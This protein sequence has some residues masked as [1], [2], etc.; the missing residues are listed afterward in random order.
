MATF[1]VISRF[2][3]TYV[4]SLYLCAPSV[5]TVTTTRTSY[6]EVRET[7]KQQIFY[8]LFLYIHYSYAVPTKDHDGPPGSP[9]GFKDCQVNLAR[10][11]N[12]VQDKPDETKS[13]DLS[14]KKTKKQKTNL[15]R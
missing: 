7:G 10:P 8:F 3:K 9:G 4:H 12:Y 6:L 1:G 13:A 15:S 11:R 14:L 5:G 2:T